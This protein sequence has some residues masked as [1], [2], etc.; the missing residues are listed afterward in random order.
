M[1]ILFF[2]TYFYPYVSGITASP[3]LALTHLSK[4]HSITVV[5]FR[6][7][8]HLPST[9][10]FG[11]IKIIRLPYFMRLSKG[12][13][14]PASFGYFIKTVADYDRVILNSPN[15]EGLALAVAA[16][17]KG[18]KIFS[19]LNCMVDIQDGIT[20]WL[21]KTGLNLSVCIQLA[22]S[23]T[24]LTYTQ[25]Y[26]ESIP[27]L[28]AFRHKVK[29]VLPCVKFK[30]P[31]PV[32]LRKL[33]EMK[34]SHVWVGFVGRIAREKGIEYVLQAIKKMRKEFPNIMLIIAGPGSE[35]VVGEKPY[36]RYIKDLLSTEQVPHRM[37]G[38]LTDRQLG[39]FY[40]KM[41]VL[42]L[43]SVNRT[44][45]FGLVQVEAMMAGTPVVA[46]SLP[47]VRIPVATTKMG[48][49]VNPR[50]VNRLKQALTHILSKRKT[51]TNTVLTT[52]ARQV[53]DI[54]KAYVT[55]DRIFSIK[56]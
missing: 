40:Q 44:E 2:S 13:L 43:P 26:F 25:D 52:H 14:S 3:L 39:A 48:I 27:S 8:S 22:L 30:T 12:F 4:K 45:A 51:Y 34:G 17:L 31:E 32:Y 50:D 38:K 16:K 6:H 46:S 35:D 11:K 23:D 49:T 54:H 18:I 53:F 10:Y 29:Y 15:F 47:G 1:K 33:N 24:I 36:H 41:D 55:Y 5:T 42:V 56:K 19:L 21:L 7:D 28:R 20:G 37:L 9:E